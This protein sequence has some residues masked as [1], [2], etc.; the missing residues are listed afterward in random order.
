M[1]QPP[2]RAPKDIHTLKSVKSFTTSTAGQVLLEQVKR[3]IMLSVQV[4][5]T[6]KSWLMSR[7]L[8]KDLRTTKLVRIHC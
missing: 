5:L 1:A 6:V 2:D 3:T 7:V 8:D 4:Q